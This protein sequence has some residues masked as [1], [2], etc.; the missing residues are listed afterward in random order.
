MSL[1]NQLGL[2]WLGGPGDYQN[3]Q[4]PYGLG[5]NQFPT[6]KEAWESMMNMQKDYMRRTPWYLLKGVPD[7]SK[8]SLAS[9][10]SMARNLWSK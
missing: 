3:I 10:R 6:P 2:G 8:W 9:S 1:L 4:N 7:M 5:F